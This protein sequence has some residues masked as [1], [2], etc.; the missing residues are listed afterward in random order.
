MGNTSIKELE[1][2]GQVSEFNSQ[3]S[4]DVERSFQIVENENEENTAPPAS[5]GIQDVEESSEKPIAK[6]KGKKEKKR[7]K[8]KQ[9]S[10]NKNDDE[11]SEDYLDKQIPRNKKAMKTKLKNLLIELHG[12]NEILSKGKPILDRLTNERERHLERIEEKEKV[13]EGKEFVIQSFH[14]KMQVFTQ[15]IEEKES[16]L[17]E[18]E[19]LL[20]EA[21]K[22]VELLQKQL[23]EQEGIVKQMQ[24]AMESL[25]NKNTNHTRQSQSALRADLDTRVELESLR[26]ENE[27]FKLQIQE[28]I[29]TLR[30][31]EQEINSLKREKE[32]MQQE[33][34][35]SDKISLERKFSVDRLNREKER[36]LAY[37]GQLEIRLTE[38]EQA[39]RQAS[40]ERAEL[41]DQLRRKETLLLE[42][43]RTLE[44]L[45][46]SR[47]GTT[48][49]LDRLEKQWQDE[50]RT[51]RSA[52]DTLRDEKRACEERL[53]RAETDVETYQR[54][55]RVLEHEIERARQTTD[56]FRG[57]QSWMISRD[58]IKLSD[59]VL[60]TGAWGRVVE[61]NFRGTKVAVKEIH[62][63]IQSAHNRLLFDR[64]ITFATLVRHPCILQ[65]LAV[66]EYRTSKPLLVAELMD[67]SLSQLVRDE[68]SLG[69]RFIRILAL[70]VAYGLNYLH[71]FRPNPILHR[72]VNSGN[73][74]VWR[75]GD[76]WRGKLCDFGSAEFMGS[77]MSEN[78]GNPFYS[79]P[80][81]SSS[82]QSPKIDVYSFGVLLCE[83]CINQTP[84]PDER[85]RQIALMWN[86]N[87]RDLTEQ[88]ITKDPSRRSTMSDVITVLEPMTM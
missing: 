88:C 83:L 6:A 30:E 78:P 9:E 72:D 53:Q 40:D 46:N 55:I 29:S 18:K 13:I 11:L 74:M 50:R 67:M 86:K 23:A 4:L 68:K 41:R 79:A 22:N 84:N 21:N 8:F 33:K 58:E 56:I 61:G 42:K 71:C 35:E 38:K 64:E 43:D 10:P 28:K 49:R 20:R 31:R 51:Q 54:R 34:R 60:G 14:E 16:E 77:K 17:R 7:E 39:L 25:S 63:I 66:A 62:E 12:K 45:E 76:K 47:K 87:L 37:L 75:Q 15:R 5:S 73:V 24:S 85:E 44:T 1:R 80:E 70:D 27:R 36:G 32:T 3:D 52:Y 65:F 57:D 59:K 48:D 69:N 26:R 19:R 2:I 82:S 81:A